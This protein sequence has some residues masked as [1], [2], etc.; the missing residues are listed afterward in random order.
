MTTGREGSLE[1]NTRETQLRV[2]LSLD[3]EGETRVDTGLPFLDHMLEQTA[4]FGG[5]GLE[6]TGKGD[7][8][9]DEH[10][11]TEDAG[12]VLGQALTEALGDRAGIRRFGSAYA[13]LDEALSRVVIDLCKRP[14]CHV[15]DG[16]RLTGKAGT[17]PVENLVEFFRAFSIHA[18]ATLHVD[19]LRGRDRHHVAES[20]FKALGL[21]LREATA[22]TGGGIP[23]SKGVL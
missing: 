15:E 16:G 2:R 4:R 8:E 9:V 22:V 3:G 6:L 7:L 18:G 1:R 20:M 12:I 21:A 19:S 10:H 23:S 17:Y 5:F 11:L 14:F 13:P